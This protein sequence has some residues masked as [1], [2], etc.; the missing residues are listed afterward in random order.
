MHTDATKESCSFIVR[1]KIRWIYDFKDRFVSWLQ[2]DV[3]LDL[4]ELFNVLIPYVYVTQ[5]AIWLLVE[6]W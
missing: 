4:A 6:Y 1:F 5:P 3:S 2:M